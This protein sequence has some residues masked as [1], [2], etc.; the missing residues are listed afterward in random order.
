MHKSRKCPHFLFFMPVEAQNITHTPHGEAQVRLIRPQEISRLS[1]LPLS[2]GLIF[3]L[4]FFNVL[5]R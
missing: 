2:F 5:I 4:I 3:F 1:R